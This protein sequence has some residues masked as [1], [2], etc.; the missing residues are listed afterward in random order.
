[1]LLK[2]FIISKF[3]LKVISIVFIAFARTFVPECSMDTILGVNLHGN[4][5][6]ESEPTKS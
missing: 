1:M 4:P 6:R 3:A 2:N 5:A